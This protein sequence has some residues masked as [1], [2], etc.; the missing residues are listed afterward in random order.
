MA[1]GALKKDAVPSLKLK[2]GKSASLVSIRR[3]LGLEYVVLFLLVVLSSLY[4][5]G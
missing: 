3:T 5:G 4:G 1:N 2:P